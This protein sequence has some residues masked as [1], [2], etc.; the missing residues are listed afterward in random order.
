MTYWR[1]SWW[2][3]H[4]YLALARG[5]FWREEGWLTKGGPFEIKAL[6]EHTGLLNG[7]SFKWVDL[8]Y[9]DWW[10]GVRFYIVFLFRLY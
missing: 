5:S 4:D 8:V 3:D 6:P 7:F 9:D 1:G 2:V 10:F